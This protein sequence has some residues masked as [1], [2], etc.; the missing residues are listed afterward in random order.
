MPT[1][2]MP[3]NAQVKKRAAPRLNEL[4][5]ASKHHWDSN[6]PLACKQLAESV[7]DG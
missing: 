5:S 4:S 2:I 3:R 6:S 7:F 1:G